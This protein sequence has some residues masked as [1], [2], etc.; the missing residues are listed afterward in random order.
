MMPPVLAVF[1]G[2]DGYGLDRAAERVGARLATTDGLAPER[3]QLRGATTSPAEV[4]ELV[5]TAPMFGGGTLVVVA[6]PSPLL[7]SDEASAALRAVLDH[8]APG[9]ALVFVAALERVA[10]AP[11]AYV[12][13]LRD[14]ILAAGGEAGEL[15]APTEG[16]LAAWIEARA[17]ERGILLARDAAQELATRVGG[18]VH[19]AD[20]DRRL[21]GH[22]AVGELEKLGTYRPGIEVSVEDV[23]ALV[24][25]AIPASGW[26]FLDSVG[27]RDVRR[28]ASLLPRL[29]ESMPEPVVVTQLHRRIRELL[30]AK[31]A[32]S[33]GAT[34]QQL[35][36][37][38]GTTSGFV[39]QK[40][41]AQSARWSIPELEAA[42]EGVLELDDRVKGST[43]SSEAQRRLAFTLWLAERV[44]GATTTRRPAARA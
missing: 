34:P 9:N 10:K 29:L 16:R 4:D 7:R 41:V 39:V 20:V 37:M 35:M 23:R 14:W 17:R 21:M 3:R 11:P 31:D 15:R 6:D 27:Q 25:E 43:G 44:G 40:L 38:V 42:L 5:A 28:A 30:I 33:G 24:P 8:V 36:R 1:W 2:D 19:E 18:F 22:L 13:R 12:A 32:T 26:A